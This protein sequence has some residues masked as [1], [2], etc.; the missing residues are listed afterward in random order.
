M[1]VCSYFFVV[2]LRRFVCVCVYR[3]KPYHSE[4]PDLLHDSRPEGLQALLGIAATCSERV[5]RHDRFCEREKRGKK[6][7]NKW[8]WK[9]IATRGTE[10][11]ER[12]RH[13]LAVP[14]T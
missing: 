8:K 7:N 2:Y 6:N 5:R 14:L 12:P 3:G 9:W 4:V 13:P 1:W 10:A 11:E